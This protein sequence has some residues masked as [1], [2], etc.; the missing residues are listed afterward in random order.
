[1]RLKKKHSFWVLMILSI[2]I[3]AFT[4]SG[5]GSE[6]LCDD[7][8]AHL[9]TEEFPFLTPDMVD[10]LDPIMDILIQWSHRYNDCQEGYKLGKPLRKRFLASLSGHPHRE[11]FSEK[12]LNTMTEEQYGQWTA[13]FDQGMRRAMLGVK[14]DTSHH[15]NFDEFRN[16]WQS[17][18]VGQRIF[19]SYTQHDQETALKFKE[20]L[21]ASG[22][23]V[24]NYM[25]SDKS[26]YTNAENTGAFFAEA[27]QRVIICSDSSKTSFGTN[28]ESWMASQ[29]K[30]L[31]SLQELVYKDISELFPMSIQKTE[32]AHIPDKSEFD[33]VKQD[34]SKMTSLSARLSY[35]QV[36]RSQLR[37]IKKL[38]NL[39]ISPG[40]CNRCH[41][42]CSFKYCLRPGLPELKTGCS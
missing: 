40:V 41:L 30:S 33:W 3:S 1:M 37:E 14:S 24:F 39:N 7:I 29:L 42:P 11:F 31:N 18:P 15:I 12:D 32:Q 26:F 27:G 17:S 23:A 38:S 8:N 6:G 36:V 2:S 10:Q 22:F 16:I 28:Y 5:T 21:E 20:L 13:E 25:K 35:I 19:L 4:F 34:L 9:L